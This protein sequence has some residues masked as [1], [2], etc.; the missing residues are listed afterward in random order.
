MNPCTNP[1][2]TRVTQLTREGRLTEALTLLKELHQIPTVDS[3]PVAVNRHPSWEKVHGAWL[4]TPLV[5]RIPESKHDSPIPGPAL[6]AGSRFESRTYSGPEGRLFYKVYVPYCRREGSPALIVMLHGC[7]QSPDDFAAGTRMNEIAEEQG[8]LVMY[9]A[10]PATANPSHCWN[11][12]RPEDQQR[13]RGE[14]ALIAAS[15]RQV[16]SDFG[17]DPSRA[18]VAGLSAGGAAAAVLGST[19]PD[20][21]AAIGVHSGL[22]CGAARDLPSAFS[23]MKRGG[24]FGHLG[25]AHAIPAIVLH[26]DR[27]QIVNPVNADQVIWQSIAI[28]STASIQ[29]GHAGGRDFTRTVYL[30]AQGVAQREQWIVHG[31]AHAWSGGSTAGSY[32]DAS[33]PD[34]SREMV[35]FFLQHRLNNVRGDEFGSR[36][37]GDAIV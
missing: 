5:S 2:M 1:K 19:Y 32:V 17:A 10:Q 20:V 12:F 8:F 7:N 15:T 3:H 30:D 4:R 24:A 6:A 27:D 13:G 36:V 23:A 37:D 33:G 18:Y 35:R 11:W 9:P 25:G 29:E 16:M 26:G 28:E 34:A 22:A 21:Y 31:A 14:P